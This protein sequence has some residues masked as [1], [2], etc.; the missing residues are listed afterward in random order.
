MRRIL[1]YAALAVVAAGDDR[2]RD[3]RW[4]LSRDDWDNLP[5]PDKGGSESIALVRG[6]EPH[7][8]PDQCFTDH[9]MHDIVHDGGCRTI[10]LS[11]YL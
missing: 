10:Q 8:H 1:L 3:R 2:L 4:L 11:Y 6:P 9:G 7:Y 5:L